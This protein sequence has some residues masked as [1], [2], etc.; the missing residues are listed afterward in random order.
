MGIVCCVHCVFIAPPIWA[1]V[2]LL[3][4]LQL[5][6][7]LECTKWVFSSA[8]L[9]QQQLSSFCNASFASFIGISWDYF[10][11]LLFWFSL[12]LILWCNTY[13]GNLKCSVNVSADDGICRRAHAYSHFF[14]SPS[15]PHLTCVHFLLFLLA[16]NQCGNAVI[17]ELVAT[18][19]LYTFLF[20]FVLHI[21]CRFLLWLKVD[22][23]VENIFSM[24]QSFITFLLHT[25]AA[26][27]WQIWQQFAQ[28]VCL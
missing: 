10:P 20:F 7:S 3:F 4:M 18:L 21:S 22:F 19:F 26:L 9:Y 16:G 2:C 28:V 11:H 8:R 14:F 5:K 13:F 6:S 17:L 1:N 24:L 23:F 27:R 12:Q 15:L 25:F